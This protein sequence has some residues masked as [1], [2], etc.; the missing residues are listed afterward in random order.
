MFQQILKCEKNVRC[1]SLF[2]A[3]ENIWP[4]NKVLN[5]VD[6]SENMKILMSPSSVQQEA[7]FFFQNDRYRLKKNMLKVGDKK[8]PFS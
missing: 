5:P 2:L 1:K 3:L 8:G 7:F 4:V 6:G